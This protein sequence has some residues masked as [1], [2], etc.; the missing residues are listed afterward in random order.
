VGC[1]TAFHLTDE[2]FHVVTLVLLILVSDHILALYQPTKLIT[3]PPGAI[4]SFPN[5]I[6]A[7]SDIFNETM[8]FHAPSSV[9]R[10][11]TVVPGLNV[12]SLETKRC[13][14]SVDG[15][16]IVTVPTSAV[17]DTLQILLDLTYHPA[18]VYELG[19]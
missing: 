14:A 3:T 10:C 1:I 11:S 7:P 6:Y 2:S 13:L 5:A 18:G 17:S 16:L 9:K 15:D 4:T 19:A 12:P 8:L